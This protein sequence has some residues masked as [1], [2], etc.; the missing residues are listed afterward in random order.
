MQQQVAQMKAQNEVLSE[1][2]FQAK[3]NCLPQNQQLA[4]RTCFRAAQRRFLRGMTYDDNW[5]VEC[6][7]MQMRSPK[8]YE[9]LRREN[10]FV[11]PGR[12]SLQKYRQW[13]KDGFGLNPNI[14]SALKEK[15]KGMDTFSRH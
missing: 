11:L 13:F 12:S 3:I 10:I 5:I 15:T 1:S 4:V 14:F 9:D 2:I 8:L 6:V 7:M